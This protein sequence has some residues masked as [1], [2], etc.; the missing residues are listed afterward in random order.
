MEEAREILEAFKLPENKLGKISC[1]TLLALCNLREKDN[2]SNAQA[3]PRTVTKDIMEFA[4]KEYG[5]DYKANTRETFRRQALHYFITAGIVELN[6]DDPGRPTNSKNNNYCLTDEAVAFIRT[7]GTPAWKS[8]LIKLKGWKSPF[9]GGPKRNSSKSSV[10]I[11]LPTGEALTLSPGK[12][13]EL[14]KAIIEVFVKQFAPNSA[15]LY[16]GDTANKALYFDGDRLCELGIELNVHDKQ[17]DVILFDG[18]KNWLYLI[19]AVTSH[20]PMNVKRI[21][22]LKKVFKRDVNPIFVTA[23]DTKATYRKFA[24]DIAWKTEVWIADEPGHLVHFD[25]ERFLGPYEI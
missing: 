24:N 11:L 1:L 14:E 22:E 4:R 23:F 2:W 12:H 21:S 18:D 13:N 8:S 10:K 17:P 5:A 7:F 6:K 15:V 3:S 19:E 25:G 9:K 20:G 16:L